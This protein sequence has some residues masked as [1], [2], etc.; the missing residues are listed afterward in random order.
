MKKIKIDLDFLFNVLFPLFAAFT[1]SMTLPSFTPYYNS[2]IK[3][4]RV[5][6][7]TFPIVW[8]VLYILMGYVGYQLS[9]NNDEYGERIYYLQ[10]L[11]NLLWSPAFFGLKSPVLGLIIILILLGLVL[12]LFIYMRKKC[13]KLANLLIPYILWLF[14]ATFLNVSL[15]ILN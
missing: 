11:L 9:K 7:V 3:L 4:V 13:Y 2:L 12:W 1:I 10:L 6:P 8:T 14:F 5:P 15:A